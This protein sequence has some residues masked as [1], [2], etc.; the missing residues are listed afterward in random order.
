MVPAVHLTERVCVND[1]PKHTALADGDQTLVVGVSVRSVQGVPHALGLVPVAVCV[2]VVDT[3]AQLIL[4]HVPVP[5]IPS[6]QV[7]VRV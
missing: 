5:A 4:E 3:P 6:V 1:R 2:S 7:R